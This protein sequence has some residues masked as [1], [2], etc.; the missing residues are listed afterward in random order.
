MSTVG[1]RREY[2][3]LDEEGFGSAHSHA[4]ARTHTLGLLSLDEEHTN[5]ESVT[6][7]PKSKDSEMKASVTALLKRSSTPNPIQILEFEFQAPT[8]PGTSRSPTPTSYH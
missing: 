6:E 5:L 8:L 4:H 2:S 3:D 1:A 7:T